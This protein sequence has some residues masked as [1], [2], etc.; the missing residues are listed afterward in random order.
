MT[1]Y[2]F[3]N[4]NLA[5]DPQVKA[6]LWD[7]HIQKHGARTFRNLAY[8]RGLH[9]RSIS[10]HAFTSMN[11]KTY[12]ALNDTFSLQCRIILKIVEIL[13]IRHAHDFSAAISVDN[14][15]CWASM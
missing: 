14:C 5:V 9:D 12:C 10:I 15:R 3:Q 8:E 13:D 2:R 1:K 6:C 7:L 4:S 11:K